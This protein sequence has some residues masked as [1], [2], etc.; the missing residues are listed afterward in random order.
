M[1]LYIIVILSL[2]ISLPINNCFNLVNLL[3][4]DMSMSFLDCPDKLLFFRFKLVSFSEFKELKLNSSKEAFRE[5]LRVSIKKD[6]I[7]HQF[8]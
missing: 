6:K 4:I 8:K 7:K 5:F 1:M 3:K 2:H